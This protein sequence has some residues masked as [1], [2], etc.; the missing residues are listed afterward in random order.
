[1]TEPVVLSGLRPTGRVH[2]GNYF[3]AVKN[4]VDLQNS[5]KYRCFFFVADLHALTT[6]YADTKALAAYTRD[7]VLDWL[8]VGLDPERATI[9]LQSRV[10]QHAELALYFSMIT[11]LGWLERVPTY[12]D[13]IEALR[14]RDL[15]THGFLGYPVLMTADIALYRS[16]LVPVGEDQASHLEICRE[17]VRRF[18]GLYGE[19]FP[20]PKALY[21]PTPKVNGVD[22][23]KMSKSYNNTIGVT[24]PAENVAQKV[25]AMVTDPARV[26]RQDPGNPENCNLFPFHVLFSPPD[27]VAV[28]DQECR[29]AARGCVDCKKH[30]ISNVNPALEPFRRKRAEILATPGDVVRE[31]LHAGDQAARVVAEETMERVREAVR[32]SPEP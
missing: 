32:L 19:V 7:A 16:S 2:L 17:I 18:N 26:R 21:T 5:K 14:S 13:Q 20:E 1:M 27:E 23:R 25:M 31:V 15:A 10:P 8:A 22:G 28:V 9:F 29:T 6:D 4:W 11:P 24:E 3:G 30:L 12:K